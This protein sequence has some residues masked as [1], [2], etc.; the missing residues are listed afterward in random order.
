MSRGDGR[1]FLLSYKKILFALYT[2]FT[3]SL[4]KLAFATCLSGQSS[5]ALPSQRPAKMLS[6]GFNALLFLPAA[7]RLAC[8]QSSNS[9]MACNNSPILCDV[10]Y[11]NITHLGAHDSPFVRDAS[12]DYS[13]SGNQVR[14]SP[15]AFRMRV[16]TCVH[17]ESPKPYNRFL[18]PS[19]YVNSE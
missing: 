17:S 10:A 3:L 16:L 2:P 9:S 15:N 11:N 5:K 6:R 18:T 19:T 8:A 14:L 12:N 7:L 1:T 13:V 4:P